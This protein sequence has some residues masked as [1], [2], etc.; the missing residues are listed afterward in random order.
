MSALP[1]TRRIWQ[2]TWRTL[3]A[4]C[5]SAWSRMAASVHTGRP[6]RAASASASRWRRGVHRASRAACSSAWTGA[7]SELTAVTGTPTGVKSVS[8]DWRPVLS[9]PGCDASSVGRVR[10]WVRPS[11]VR[12]EPKVL[13]QRTS[14][15]GYKTVRLVRDGRNRSF[16]VHRLVLEAFTG[17]VGHEA[18]HMNGVR[19]DNAI[20]NLAWGS[21]KENSADRDLHGTTAHGERMGSAKLK[22]EQVQEITRAYAS[23]VLPSQLG[24]RFGISREHARRVAQ[25]KY[26]KRTRSETSCSPVE[27]A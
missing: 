20:A 27:A 7:G 3:S 4:R 10:T 6:F 18:R 5:S 26:W 15:R 23:G 8:E 11:G 22:W 21:P 25:G 24:K 19:D 17:V 13:Y 1:S 12:G 9:V 2:Q 16:Q 14:C